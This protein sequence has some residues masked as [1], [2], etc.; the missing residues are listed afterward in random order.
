MLNHI[1]QAG[2]REQ[3]RVLTGGGGRG[4]GIESLS[5]LPY[6]KYSFSANL[7]W[8]AELVTTGVDRWGDVSPHFSAWE[9]ALEM[10]PPTFFSLKNVQAYSETDHSSLLKKPSSL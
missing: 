9:T 6:R 2:L 7:S 1:L 4:E 5:P 8:P 3:Y 10:P